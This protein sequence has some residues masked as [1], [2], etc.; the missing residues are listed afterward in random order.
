M[1]NTY[2][3][4]VTALTIEDIPKML[5]KL[6]DSKVGT[7]SP[8]AINRKS[9]GKVFAW[10]SWVLLIATSLVSGPKGTYGIY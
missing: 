6:G 9:K 2:Q 4:L 7:N 1:S 8:F 3:T 5:K 10:L